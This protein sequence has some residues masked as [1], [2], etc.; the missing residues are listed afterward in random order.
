[1]IL[2]DKI[3]SLRKK[4][5]WSQEE[6]ADQLGI[7]RQSVSKWESGMSIP[8]LEKIVRMS[9]LFGVS[10]DYLLKDE[11]ENELPS[12]TMTT[13]DNILRSVSLE[14]AS[15]YMNLVKETAPKFATAV[16]ALI[17]SP[18]PL[19]LLG[20]MAETWP[21][22]FSED[23]LSGIGIIILLSIVIV[24]VIPLILNSMKL[25]KYEY[26]EKE[27]INLLYGVKGV[28]EKRKDDF[29]DT[30]RKAIAG[31]VG[32]CIFA[33]IPLISFAIFGTNE[34]LAACLVALLLFF[35]SS[36]VFLF[37]SCGLV[38]ESFSK[39][40]QEGDFALDKKA[41]SRM[42]EKVAGAYWCI[43]T[44]IY[45]LWSFLTNDWGRT[46]LVWPVA[47]VLFGT[48]ACITRLLFGKK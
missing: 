34:M 36:G 24:S 8:D 12:E 17:L 32:L 13:D 18:V 39:L 31:G 27:E 30:Y 26:L 3:M 6:L 46:W 5:G 11:I 48:V 14:E 1:M 37:V 9:T 40:L 4:N 38:H 10:T 21:E 22:K 16:S 25:S 45:L 44:A 29:E 20:G 2:A 15:T 19:L 41:D 7:S 23:I 43:V 35:V 28:V 47:G 33:A 42:L